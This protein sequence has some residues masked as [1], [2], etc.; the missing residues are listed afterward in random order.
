MRHFS[1]GNVP[2]AQSG[3]AAGAVWLGRARTGANCPGAGCA[4]RRLHAAQ[5]ASVLDAA[6]VLVVALPPGREQHM[7]G[8]RIL[9]EGNH[10]NAILRV[11]ARSMR[12]ITS[13]CCK[14]KMGGTHSVAKHGV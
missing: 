9:P 14:L 11:W 7:L 6:E 8:H 12:F 10:P 3:V 4:S 5:S 2:G 1:G 13:P